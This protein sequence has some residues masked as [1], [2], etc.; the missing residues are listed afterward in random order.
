MDYSDDIL[1]LLILLVYVFLGLCMG[2]FAS[3]ISYRIQNGL[4]WVSQKDLVTGKTKPVRSMCPNCGHQL[5]IL[6]LI[7]LLSWIFFIGKCRYCAS[8]IPVRYPLI[9]VAA[10][11]VILSYHFLGFGYIEMAIYILLLPFSLS[12]ILLIVNSFNPPKYIYFALLSNIAFLV[13][14]VFSKIVDT[15]SL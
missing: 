9:E 8:K 1:T 4:S 11:L 14:S 6:D 7:P 10:S 15:N 3:A 5:S 13:Y 2:S 12:F